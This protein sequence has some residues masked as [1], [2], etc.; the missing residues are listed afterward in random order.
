MEDLQ[1]NTPVV[2]ALDDIKDT[3]LALIKIIAKLINKKY[4]T[5]KKA[6]SELK[7]DQPKVS[8]IHRLKIEGFSLQYLLER[9]AALDQNVE[10]KIK[11][12]SESE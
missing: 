2:I 8:Q 12:N 5:Q 3:K 4:K 10:I 7:I 6:G 11:C 1:L 9:L